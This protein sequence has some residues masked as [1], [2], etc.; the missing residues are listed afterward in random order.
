[1]LTTLFDNFKAI[2]MDP[3]S[4]QD[5][6][7][8]EPLK[9]EVIYANEAAADEEDAPVPL[10]KCEREIGGIVLRGN[11]I[12]LVRSLKKDF[13]GLRI[14]SAAPREG[15]SEEACAVRAVARHCEIDGDEEVRVLPYVPHGV[16]YREV[17][18]NFTP[19]IEIFDMQ[20]S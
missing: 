18:L 4:K 14:P 17:Q 15:E 9:S 7:R 19:E 8:C 5:A 10:E 16:V 1:M 12:V 13:A 2:E 6:L 11:R 20:L 3:R